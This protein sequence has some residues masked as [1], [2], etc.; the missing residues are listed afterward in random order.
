MNFVDHATD[1]SRKVNPDNTS[2]V[3]A[4]APLTTNHSIAL[5]MPYFGAFPSHF[6]LFLRCVRYNPS[7]N[8]IIISDIEP[9]KNL[10]PNL[11]FF[12]QSLVD[13]IEL[14]FVRCGIRPSIYQPAD[15]CNLR[16]AFGHIFSD[17]L[18]GYNFWGHSDLDLILGDLRTFLPAHIMGSHDRVYCRGHL[19]L[20]RNE[21]RVNQ[22]F[23][24]ETPGVPTFS[25][26]L[27]NPRGRQYDEW[28]GIHR[29][30]RYHGFS[31]YHDEVI[32]DIV[33]PGRYVNTRFEM[34][35]LP[36]FE[37]QFFYWFE[38]R[39][40]QTFLHREGGILDKE[41]AYIHFQK[42]RLPA[43]NSLVINAKGF[44]VGP[45]GFAPY[46]REPLSE[47]EIAVLN[48]TSIKPLGVIWSEEI[49]RARSKFGK[50]F[51]SQHS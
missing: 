14:A 23:S 34:T 47:R 37:S 29:I 43:P 20:Y 41:V 22:A 28:K 5:L 26:I 18:E 1:E 25:D 42:R 27:Q 2:H 3:G 7:I 31:Q 51:I 45:M 17:L 16:P 12:R 39:T 32:A 13:L 38:G 15:L 6:D 10:P 30:M 35:E 44:S 19:S 8:W 33:P 24:L 9:P 46:Q 49:K 40:Y 36:N 50:I 48:P 11:S 21:E 4:N